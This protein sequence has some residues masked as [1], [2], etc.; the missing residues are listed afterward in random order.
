MGSLARPDEAG[1]AGS[2]ELEVYDSEFFTV[3]A[4]SF[5]CIETQLKNNSYLDVSARKMAEQ[6]SAKN[7]DFCI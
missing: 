2:R 3:F 1:S 7:F 4:A 6:I 5:V